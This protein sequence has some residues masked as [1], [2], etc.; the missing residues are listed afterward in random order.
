M[1]INEEN[2]VD[3]AEKA[4][5]ESRKKNMKAQLT[6]TQL[7]NILAMTADIYN[8]VM[9]ESDQTLSKEIVG[10]IEYLKIRIIYDVGREKPKR[11][12]EN[13]VKEAELLEIISEIGNSRK[14]FIMFHRYMEAL[15]AYHKYYGGKEM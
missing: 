6:T 8:D 10:R 2:F 9:N 3:K 14:N 5:S 12:L 13:F 4:I 11:T 15:V 1:R 7:R